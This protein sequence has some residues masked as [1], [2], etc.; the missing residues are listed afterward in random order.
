MTTAPSRHRLVEIKPD[1]L[2]DRL[3][4][5]LDIYVSAMG[6][7]PNT[8]RSRRSLWLDHV[9]RPGWRSVGALDA[10]GDLL[11]ITYGY[12]GGPGQWWFEEVQRGLRGL[13]S[14]RQAWLADYFELTEL[15]VRPEAQGR[16]IGEG[17]LRGLLAGIERTRVLLS[18]PEHA[19]GRPSRAWQLY[20][21]IGFLDVL[22]EHRFT[23]DARPFAVLGRALPLEPSAGLSTHDHYSTR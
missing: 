4:D 16:G 14:E 15:H 7:P 3:T 21:R 22:R 1:G 2:A 9:Q 12:V 23:G 20:R 19:P 13:R 11:G 6:Y 17:L 8:A 10:D 5:A 18:T